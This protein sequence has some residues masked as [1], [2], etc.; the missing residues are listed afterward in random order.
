M[1]SPCAHRQVVRKATTPCQKSAIFE[2]C[3][4]TPDLLVRHI[5]PFKA[6]RKRNLIRT[7]ANQTNSSPANWNARDPVGAPGTEQ[8]KT[9]NASGVPWGCSME[10]A[11]SADV[12]SK[13]SFSAMGFNVESCPIRDPHGRL[14]TGP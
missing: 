2:P 7:G 11:K 14:G 1:H 8:S 3:E 12:A 6:R 5:G 4:P 10:L 9:S 13:R